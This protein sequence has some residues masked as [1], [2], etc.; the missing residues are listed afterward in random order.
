MRRVE[1][2]STEFLCWIHQRFYNRL[3]ESLQ[4]AQDESGRPYKVQP[5][6]PR[7][8]MVEADAHTPPRADA[9]PDFLQR[10]CRFYSSGQI[11]SAERLIAIAAAH[12]RLAWIHPF[13]DGNGRV[14]RLH[15]QALLVKYGLDSHGL[16]SL[17]RGLA[18]N[19]SD[20]YK[21][22]AIA[23]QE[24]QGDLDGRG[25]LS[26]AGLA[27]FCRFFLETALDQ[28]EFMTNLLDL[29]ILRQR[30]ETFFALSSERFGKSG[31]SLMRVIRVLVDE[32]EIERRRVRD[33]TG[34]KATVSADIIKL[35]L[36][37]GLMTSSGARG[38]L[39][40]AFPEKT[41]SA[42]FPKLYSENL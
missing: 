18:R 30:V 1:A 26:D 42:Y 2:F 29:H 15:T 23:D 33:I 31:E 4:Y 16:W 13:G 34:K 5:G 20:Y 24:R 37:E 12:H 3:P 35:G 36:N 14:T 28:I 7:D 9:L 8:F 17:S 22:L 21:H 27:S 10:F 32:G 41:L 25:N 38:P 39:R 40:I 11:R 6:E 19:R